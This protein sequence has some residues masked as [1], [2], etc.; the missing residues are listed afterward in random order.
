MNYSNVL[1]PK[2]H[3]YLILSL[4]SMIIFC[5]CLE[6]IVSVKQL[7]NYVFVNPSTSIEQVQILMVFYMMNFLMRI[8]PFMIL[9]IHSYIA[10]TKFPI[11]NI[12]VFIWCVIMIGI[13][14]FNLKDFDFYSL[15]Y[16]LRFIGNF[17]LILT[18]FNLTKVI[19]SKKTL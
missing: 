16:Y 19:K 11:N 17:A 4:C 12:F 5:E 3:F 14:L 2:K 18:V 8:V 10:F 1:L 7:R 13:L 15:F 9:G 6:A